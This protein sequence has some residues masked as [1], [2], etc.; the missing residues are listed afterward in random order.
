MQE[1]EGLIHAWRND[2]LD[3]MVA[4]SAFGVGMDKNNV[5]SVL[6]VAVPEN[7]DRFYQESGRGG[8][9]GKASVAHIIFHHKQL[10]VARNINRT[11]LIGASKGYLRWAKMHQLREQHQPGQFIVPLRAKHADIRMDS[12]SNV[13]WNLRTL[14]LMQRA[15][16]IDIAYPPP[17]LSAIAPDERDEAKIR[18]W[19]DHY[20]NHI[21]VSVR[22]DGHMDEARWHEAFRPTVRM[23][24]GCENRDIARWRS[25]SMTL[26]SRCAR[27]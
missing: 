26:Q 23:N 27:S 24:W 7:L 16:F 2:G 8:R 25:G 15:G 10:Q 5:R 3:I 14:L 22:R 6:H 18:A 20:F 19:F 13:D 4:T 21:Q 1:R 12:Q 9:D 17:D 11:K